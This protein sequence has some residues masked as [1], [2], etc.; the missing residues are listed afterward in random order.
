MVAADTRSPLLRFGAFE[1]DRQSGEL[2]RNG[3]KVRLGDQPLR[4]L[5]LLVDRP[6]ELVTREQLRERLWSSDTYVDFDLGL[7]SAIRRLR[8]ALD[9]SA[10]NPRFVQ[11]VPRRGYRFIV[12]VTPASSHPEPRAADITA[13]RDWRVRRGWTVGAGVLV[14]AIWTLFIA[15]E[16]KWWERPPGSID[17]RSLA[18]LPF[19]NLTGDATQEYLVDGIT[20]GVTTNLAQLGGFDVLSETSAMRYKGA[21]KPA[22]AREL[23]VD[24][25]LD[26]SV[27]RAGRRVLITARLI[28]AATD[29]H[30]WAQSHEGEADEVITLQHQIAYA[31]GAL[32]GRDRRPSTAAALRAVNPEAYDAYLKGVFAFGGQSYEQYQTAISHFERAV[33]KQPDFAD[34]YAAIAMIQLQFLFFGPLPPHEVIPKAEKAARKAIQLDEANAQAHKTLGTILHHYH[35]NWEE[36]NREFQR[37]RELRGGLVEPLGIGVVALVRSGRRD[38]A[39]AVATIRREL[40]LRPGHGRAHFQL[41]VTLV[42]M[43]RS[44]DAISEFETAVNATPIGNPRFLAYLGYAYAAAGRPRDARRILETLQARARQ[45]Y[46]SAF[47]LALIYDA[48]GEKAAALAAFE[49]AYQDHAVELAQVDQYPPFRTIAAEPQFIDRIR[50]IGLPR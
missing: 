10:D 34:A 11:T 45:Q 4:I 13:S 20:V 30:I 15:F 14:L 43:G 49:R 31:I 29:R 9:D 28:Q 16:R 41:G 22:A 48:L 33:D 40:E 24:T 25:L 3:M 19:D 18:V 50:R 27:A 23:G 38:E 35:W 32:V 44:E 42:L 5:E 37:A 21:R 12:P 47:G 39:M 8:E 6:G 2:R 17:I 46:V 36:G 1:L 26:G 7:N